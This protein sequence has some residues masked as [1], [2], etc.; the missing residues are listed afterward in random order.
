MAK[1]SKDKTTISISLSK[2]VVEVLNVF[3]NR[4]KLIDD[5]L[6]SLLLNLSPAEMLELIKTMTNG[7]DVIEFLI[8]KKCRELGIQMQVDK[9]ED[10]ETK[11][12][13]EPKA[14]VEEKKSN[15]VNPQDWWG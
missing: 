4:S 11:Q 14:V 2:E 12:V 7:G 3:K 13:K 8:K 1:L 9:T 15:K 6:S 5:I 10:F